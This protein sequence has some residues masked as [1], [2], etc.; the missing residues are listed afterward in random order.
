MDLDDLG[1]V[2]KGFLPRDGIV[3]KRGHS[4]CPL[5]FV[6]QKEMIVYGE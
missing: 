1:V 6:L 2:L 4:F 3:R 5:V